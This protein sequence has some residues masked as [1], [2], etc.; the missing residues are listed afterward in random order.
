MTAITYF[1]DRGDVKM[2]RYLVSRGASTT[3]SG[4]DEDRYYLPMYAAVSGGHLDICKVLHA[5]GAQNDVRGGSATEDGWTPFAKAALNGQDEVVRWLTIHGALC[6]DDE[7][8]EIQGDIIYPDINKSPYVRQIRDTISSSCKR[9]V[10]WAEE[11][12]QSHSAVITFLGGALPPAPD[13]VQS[14]TLQCL[15][16]QPGVRKHIAAL[17]GWK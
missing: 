10:K 2:C 9:L 1:A 13:T 14:R 12:T 3:K 4:A 5:H 17:S 6:F 11:V 16:G 15:C 7:S 8:E